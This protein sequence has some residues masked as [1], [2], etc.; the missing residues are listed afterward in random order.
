MK[1]LVDLMRSYESYHTK[2]VTKL[3]HFV[4]VP[5]IT[6]SILMIF[7]WIHV[8]LFKLSLAWL[9]ISIL[10]LYYLWLDFRLGLVAIGIF[11]PMTYAATA[12]AT[13]HFNLGAFAL[14]IFLFIG[15]WV[16]QLLGHYHEGNRPAL[17]DNF[18]QVIVAPI[19]LIAEGVFRMGY[20]KALKQAI[21]TEPN[22]LTR[23]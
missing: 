7:N 3:T 4:G 15:G 1:T 20:R 19:F 22:Q 6:F 11:L 8:P 13:N 14:F 16:L 10:L 18:F 21:T 17:I 5:A 23:H 12:I 9:S 2:N